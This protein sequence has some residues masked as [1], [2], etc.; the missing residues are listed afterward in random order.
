MSEQCKQCRYAFVR[1]GE[2]RCQ[3][4]F[5]QLCRHEDDIQKLDLVPGVCRLINSKNDCDVF[6][7][8]RFERLKR[9]L[10]RFR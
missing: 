9:V 5:M 8:K 4:R 2:H 10:D 6:Q 1:D 7:P 3:E